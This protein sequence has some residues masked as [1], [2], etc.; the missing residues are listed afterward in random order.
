MKYAKKNLRSPF[1]L[2]KY[3]LKTI[4]S[5]V[6]CSRLELFIR[7]DVGRTLFTKIVTIM[8]CDYILVFALRQYKC[9]YLLYRYHVST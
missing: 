1:F 5:L 6:V 7:I 4:P 8:I 2:F 3:L 9:L